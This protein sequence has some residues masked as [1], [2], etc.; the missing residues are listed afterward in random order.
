[1]R[2]PSPRKTKVVCV[3]YLCSKISCLSWGRKEDLE[4]SNSHFSHSFARFLIGL[5]HLLR[6]TNCLLGT[7][8][9]K[10]P[11]KH[12]NASGET[13]SWRA[14]T[15]GI[16]NSGLYVAFLHVWYI[17]ISH[18]G[19]GERYPARTLNPDLML[20]GLVILGKIICLLHRRICQRPVTYFNKNYFAR[21]QS[22]SVAETVCQ[23]YWL[24]ASC[25]SDEC[26]THAVPKD[27]Q[28][29]EVIFFFLL[30]S[31]PHPTPIS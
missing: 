30:P 28:Q 29:T 16:R 20:T 21:W 11:I 25:T 15:P 23:W 3:L 6:S 13:A 2:P 14:A 19:L 24:R 27:V 12:T 10:H 4:H 31:H 22:W 9:L 18:S 7:R 26:F 8:R 1:M 17:I 5:L